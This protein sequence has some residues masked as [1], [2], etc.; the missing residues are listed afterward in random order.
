MN[1]EIR[2]T[3]EEWQGHIKVMSQAN[4]KLILCMHCI[5]PTRT[6]FMFFSRFP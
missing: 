5:L 3:V 4:V 2:C 1:Y 6:L